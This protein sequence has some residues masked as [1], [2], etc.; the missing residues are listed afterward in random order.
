M[1]RRT[2][3][4]HLATAVTALYSSSSSAS[5]IRTSP[6]HCDHIDSSLSSIEQR[7]FDTSIRRQ[8]PHLLVIGALLAAY[9]YSDSFD[10]VDNESSI[11]AQAII[12]VVDSADFNIRINNNT[13]YLRAI[14]CSIDD[15]EKEQ[16]RSTL[17]VVAFT[18]PNRLVGKGYL[19]IDTGNTFM[20]KVESRLRTSN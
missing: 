19:P 10:L 2:L 8:S 13:T 7:V 9:Y 14:N 1:R 16:R 11:G 3:I 5:F 6:P 4:R 20:D 17:A 18:I 12:A 15:D